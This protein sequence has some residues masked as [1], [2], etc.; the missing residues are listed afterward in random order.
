[1]LKSREQAK[2]KA[3]GIGDKD[4]RL[5]SKPAAVQNFVN[6]TVCCGELKMTKSNIDAKIHCESKHPGVPFAQCFPGQFDPT[7]PAVVEAAAAAAAPV[8]AVQGPGK[9][10][11]TTDMSFLQ[12]ALIA[13]PGGKKGKK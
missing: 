11:K 9:A 5:P 6:C 4:G 2:N 7:A 1:M 12:E 3:A 13:G 10:K 8:K